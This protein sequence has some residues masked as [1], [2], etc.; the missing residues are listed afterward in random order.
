M[1]FRLHMTMGSAK[2]EN[3]PS[4]NTPASSNSFC[5]KMNGS[6]DKTVVCTRCYSINTEKRYPTLVNALE[7]NAD[8]YK[9]I[10]LNTELPRLNFAIA[11]FD[12][13]GE[14]HNEIHVLN[15]FNLA[16][17]N[18]ETTFGFWTKRKDLIKAV[19]SMISKPANV[20]LIHSST[21]MN[22]IDKLPAGYDKVFTA[23]KK[24]DLSANVTINCSQKCNDCRLCYSHNDIV[25][26]NEIA[27]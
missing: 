21:K 16:R 19:L 22:K 7:R 27:K 17:K 23:H 25:Y 10:L 1:T 24:S 11:R 4:F 2:M 9:R 8:L 3:I 20:I 5:I 6:A 12:S 13:F 18:P 15:Y 26:I 14:V